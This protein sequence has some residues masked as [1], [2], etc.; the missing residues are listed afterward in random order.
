MTHV[1]HQCHT[2]STKATPPSSGIPYG[3]MRVIFIQITTSLYK[4]LFLYGSLRQIFYIIAQAGLELTILTIAQAG[5][6]VII[7]QE[8]ALSLTHI[9]KN[10]GKI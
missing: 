6:E 2:H 5:L 9:L 10:C 1:L 8:P 3:I 4:F 7:F